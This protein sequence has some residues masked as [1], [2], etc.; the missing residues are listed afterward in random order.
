MSQ[1]KKIIAALIMV[2]FTI[3]MGCMVADYSISELTGSEPLTNQAISKCN[4][5]ANEQLSRLQNFV[6]G[7]R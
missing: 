4:D 1:Q 3:I 5:F 7:L 2:V 6:G